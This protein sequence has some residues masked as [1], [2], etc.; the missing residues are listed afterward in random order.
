[1]VKRMK[2]RPSARTIPTAK[3][4]SGAR[5]SNLGELS[6]TDVIGIILVVLLAA[7]PFGYGKYL[8]FNTNDPFD[9]GLNVYSAH[10]LVAG[11]KLNAEVIPSALPATLL[12]NFVGVKLWGFSEFGPKLIQTLMQMLALGLMFYTLRK[13]YG[14]LAAGAAVVMAAF[15]LSCPPFA[16]FGNVKEQ[17]MI[18]CMITAACG[19][20]LY[21]LGA[22]RG[23]LVLAGATAINTYYFK[24]TGVSIILAIGIY[25]LAQTFLRRVSFRQLGRA[26]AYL[27]VGAGV[28][29][30]PLVI[31]YLWQG[32][33]GQLLGRFPANLVAI[34]L[35]GYIF[36][37]IIFQAVCRLPWGRL[38]RGFSAAA[39]TVVVGMS[40]LLLIY[41]SVRGARQLIT[42]VQSLGRQVAELAGGAGGYVGSSR[43]ASTF[44]QQFDAVF[45]YYQSFVVPIGLSLLAIFWHGQRC[46]AGWILKRSNRRAEKKG[47]TIQPETA[48]A[49]DPIEGIV[50]LFGMWW[51]LDML[52]IW[53][54][55]RSYVQY[56]LPPSA[57]AAMLAAYAIYRCQQRPLGYVWLLAVWLAVDFLVKW[58]QPSDSILGIALRS[59]QAVGPYWGGFLLRVLVLAGAAIFYLAGRSR[60]RQAAAI[61]L[62]LV[63]GGMFFWWNSGSISEFSNR[64]EETRLIEQKGVKLPWEAIGEY[65]SQNST[66]ADGLYVWGWFPGIYVAAQRL[67]PARHPS[68]SNMHTDSP[69]LLLLKTKELVAQLEAAPPKFIV[70][71]QKDHFPYYARPFFPSHPRFDLWPR[72]EVEKEGRIT[73]DLRPR[74]TKDESKYEYMSPNDLPKYQQQIMDQVQSYTYIVLSYKNRPGGPLTKEQAGQLAQDEKARHEAMESLREFVMNNYQPISPVSSGMY[75]FVRKDSLRG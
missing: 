21:R 49:I 36:F 35:G 65:I 69:N 30:L 48:Q 19:V 64:V 22:G 59:G 5:F 43:E 14:T 34:M 10:C 47:G 70:D 55:P 15:Y 1:M 3:T 67:S 72:V 63:C 31:F 4:G 46:W 56:Y 9:S 37:L 8:E 25:L 20:V 12:I 66:P 6:R 52:F 71:T 29:L 74:L 58:V 68:E 45:G 11:Q 73:F 41:G 51:L 18:A 32:Q 24:P 53:I 13:T 62:G 39:V 26:F 33:V 60:S 54:S 2:S 44:R 27:L 23:W 38:N 61:V 17:F 40:A 42:D 28:G 75:V 7:I 16:K 57:S 50:V